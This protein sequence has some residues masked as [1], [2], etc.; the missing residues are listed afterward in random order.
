MKTAKYT[1]IENWL[2]EKIELTFSRSGGPGGQNVNKVNTKVTARINIDSM[3]ILTPEEKELVKTRLNTRINEEGELVIS[4]TDTRSQLKNREIA[5]IRLSSLING[6][7]FVHKKRKKTRPS[8]AA[9]EK[10]LNNKKKISQ[11]KNRRKSEDY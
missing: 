10:R 8:R 2:T 1:R 5:L 9:R 7:L 3:D 6:S 11:K 4:V